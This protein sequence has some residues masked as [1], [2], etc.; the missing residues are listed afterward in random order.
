MN[1]GVATNV[2][3]KNEK[4]RAKGTFY[5]AEILC[6]GT[7]RASSLKRLKLKL[8]EVGKKSEEQ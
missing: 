8:K 5:L 1:E 3:Q 4:P 6:E 2:T 7:E